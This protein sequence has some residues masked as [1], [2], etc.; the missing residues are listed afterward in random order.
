MKAKMNNVR[1]GG[2]ASKK[3]LAA[4]AVL[5]VAFAVFAAVPV[6]A[7]DSDAAD[8]KTIYVN[9]DSTAATEDG[10]KDAP[11]MTIDAAFEAATA[12]DKVQIVG[13][14]MPGEDFTVPAGKT[15]VVPVTATLDCSKVK[16]TVI[17]T[18][19]VSGILVIKDRAGVAGADSTGA[20]KIVI[21][22]SAKVKV[23]TQYYIGTNDN[24]E[25]GKDDSGMVQLG[26][27]AQLVISK[28][29]STNGYTATVQGGKVALTKAWGIGANTDLTVAK[30]ATVGI[31]ANFK[32]S[33]NITNNG[34]LTIA[35]GTTVTVDSNTGKFTNTDDGTVVLGGGTI[36][37]TTLSGNVKVP[38]NVTIDTY[39][40][41]EAEKSKIDI[42]G[43]VYTVY[44]YNY[45]NVDYQY[46]LAINPVAYTGDDIDY[47]MLSVISEPLQT[48]PET[49]LIFSNPIAKWCNPVTK[50]TYDG[51]LE[52][53]GA[54][55]AGTYE[56]V[57]CWQASIAVDVEKD[58]AFN[59]NTIYNYL[60][61]EITKGQ[62]TGTVEIKGWNLGQYDKEENAPK[63]TVE[64]AA[65]EPVSAEKY[66]VT[67]E[68]FDEK[69]KS[70]GIDPLK[71]EPGTYYVK[72]TIV[73][74]DTNFEIENAPIAMF[75]VVR[76]SEVEFHPIQD[77]DDSETE[78]AIL[79][80]VDP[81]TIQ[82]DSIK[83]NDMGKSKDGTYNLRVN[84]TVYEIAEDAEEFEILKAL[85]N[86]E[87]VPQE[88]GYFL[89]FYISGTD[90]KKL[91]DDVVEYA[92]EEL[93]GSSDIIMYNLTVPKN[94]ENENGYVFGILYM[95]SL[96]ADAEEIVDPAAGK[97]GFTCK[98]DYDGSVTVYN[99]TTYNVD[100]S[101]LNCYAIVLH[102]N[103][104]GE[105]GKDYYNDALT[106]YRANGKQFTL[107]SGAAEGFKYWTTEK[108]VVNDRTFNFGAVMIVGEKY[109]TNL[110]G[111]IDLYATYGSGS[112]PT[113][114][115]PTTGKIIVTGFVQDG[116]AYF[117]VIADDGLAIP[118]GTLTVGYYHIDPDFGSQVPGVVDT[119]E[120]KSGAQFATIAVDVPEGAITISATYGDA[121]SYVFFI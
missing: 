106:Y 14:Y 71:L 13:T 4:I 99:T 87:N 12:N 97:N 117:T 93:A 114:V 46:G 55:G 20:C 57:V 77:L 107:P 76:A 54:P 68:Y 51:V 31:A 100:T 104:D 21:N 32:V 52:A 96:Q 33:G 88:K 73:P 89:A 98:V 94:F 118:A 29:E 74:K 113:P 30:D 56:G 69:N 28:L 64:D 119:L 91:T 3:L 85:F 49:K 10:T 15:L 43:I 1:G 16:L 86:T 60:D 67:Y 84:G 58:P 116:K 53:E 41:M 6:I 25:S 39:P 34:T 81:N 108:G 110:D 105:D 101:F 92:M 70:K 8:G 59:S 11:F 111:T 120:V 19:D 23:G 61:F 38:A 90:G 24:G 27:G 112:E 42:D 36:T 63:V 35:E 95:S 82:K 7:D 40:V 109:D 48:S 79:G 66:N 22:A 103:K 102:D 72:A 78:K 47:R 18:L 83:F 26:E 62:Y 5:A 80:G 9:S 17:G 65:G 2:I 37:G 75:K 44:V 50:K 115:E 121:Q 45:K